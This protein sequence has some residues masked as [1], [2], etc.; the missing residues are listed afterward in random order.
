MSDKNDILDP[1]DPLKTLLRES[2][3][4]QAPQT[5]VSNVM[6][7]IEAETSTTDTGKPLITTLGWVLIGTGLTALS[8]L[9]LLTAE[10][11][12]GSEYLAP[13][14]R[15]I[16]NLRFPSIEF[17]HFPDTVWLGVL[18]FGFYGLLHLFWMKRQM[19]QQRLF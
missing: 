3:M 13:L 12:E 6:R 4:E 16:E 11:G 15:W 2:A 8:L 5:L 10:R 17:S 14:S 1:N 18:A 9:S 19:D 7:V